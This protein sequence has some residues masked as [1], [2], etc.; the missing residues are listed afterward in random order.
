MRSPV[1]S[2]T[3]ACLLRVYAVK[4]SREFHSKTSRAL[5]MQEVR[6]IMFIKKH[7]HC[8]QYVQAWEQQG[9]VYLQ[10]EFCSA[11]LHDVRAAPTQLDL[12]GTS[13]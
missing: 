2:T 4:K 5:M 13:H 3:D 1:C 12:C 6:N 8:L 10:M 7:R 11:T 9:H